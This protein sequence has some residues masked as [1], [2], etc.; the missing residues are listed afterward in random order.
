MHRYSAVLMVSQQLENELKGHCYPTTRK[1][2]VLL[3][4]AVIIMC[5]D[6]QRYEL[7][8]EVEQMLAVRG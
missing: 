4:S 1:L 5:S 8:V 7:M 6:V 3:T 2:A